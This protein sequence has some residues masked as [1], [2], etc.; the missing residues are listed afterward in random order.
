MARRAIARPDPDLLA[1]ARGL[2]EP[3]PG[4][5]PLVLYLGCAA[6][7]GRESGLRTGL[8]DHLARLR[9]FGD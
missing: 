2:P 9:A 7:Y 3:G 1:P 4:D 6:E 5:D 8:I